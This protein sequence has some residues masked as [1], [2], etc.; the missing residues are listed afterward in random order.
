MNPGVTTT[1]A[2]GMATGWGPDGAVTGAA[3]GTA[4]TTAA[5][6]AAAMSAAVPHTAAIRVAARRRPIGRHPPRVRPRRSPEVLGDRGLTGTEETIIALQ[7]M[8]PPE[9]A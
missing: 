1:A 8:V 4:V 2:G 7:Q 3:I 9:A 5:T 6:G